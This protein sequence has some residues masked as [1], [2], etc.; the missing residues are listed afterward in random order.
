MKS[1][2]IADLKSRLSA[3]LR[4]VRR[5]GVVTVL[6]RDTPVARIVPVDPG[7]DITITPAAS[8]APPLGRVRL[9]RVARLKVDVVELLLDDRRRR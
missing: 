5:G 9:P 4:E 1:V 6:A 8:G 7:A 3:H 2:K